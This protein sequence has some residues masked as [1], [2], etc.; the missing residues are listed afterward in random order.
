MLF[1]KGNS[2]FLIFLSIKQIVLLS[3]NAHLKTSC[4]YGSS[5]EENANFA[6]FS[7]MQG[8]SIIINSL[9]VVY[10]SWDGSRSI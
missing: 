10:F 4:S 8:N 7:V 3:S 5:M 2:N 6:F 9:A 1:Y